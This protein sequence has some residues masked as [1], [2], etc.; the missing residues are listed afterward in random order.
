MLMESMYRLYPKNHIHANIMIV[1][2]AEIKEKL[3]EWN[4]KIKLIL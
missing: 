3:K 2:K 1:N 4:N